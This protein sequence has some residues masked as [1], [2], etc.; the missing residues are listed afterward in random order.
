MAASS[1]R[2]NSGNRASPAQR[3]TPAMLARPSAKATFSCRRSAAVTQ[4]SAMSVRAAATAPTPLGAVKDYTK[5]DWSSFEF[6]ATPV[7]WEPANPT[8][9][10]ILTI[11]FNP[12]LTVVED[13]GSVAFNGGFNGPFMCGGAPRPMASK[14]RGT[15]APPLYSIRVNIPKFASFLQFGFTDGTNWDEGYKLEVTPLPENKGRDLAFF[16]EGLSREM[17]VD[18]ACEAAIFPDPA[19]VP[20][21][22]A[23]PGG[24]GLVGQSCELDVVPGCTDPDA[25]NF[26]PLAN[27]ED[28]SCELP[29]PSKMK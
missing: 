25:P 5:P 15:S 24:M 18:G 6:G 29:D 7:F 13:T 26:D 1:V 17:G 10:D 20:L 27:V 9:G 12:D 28:S 8:A 16:N 3:A 11:W 4:R 14:S 2:V 23:M 21:T 22:C 19:P